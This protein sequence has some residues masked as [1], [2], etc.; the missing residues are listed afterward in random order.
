MV[1]LQKLPIFALEISPL[2]H[3][4]VLIFGLPTNFTP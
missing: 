4:I 1:F 2:H 3:C